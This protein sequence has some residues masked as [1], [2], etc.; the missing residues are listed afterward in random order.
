MMNCFPVLYQD[1]LFY[2]I[3]ARYKRMCGIFSKKALYRDFCNTEE[4]Q[5]FMYLPLHIKALVGNLPY[6]TKITESYIINNHT[7]YP[8]LT[9]F[10]SNDRADIIYSEMLAGSKKNLLTYVGANSTNSRFDKHLKYCNQCYKEDLNKLGESY[11]R[12]IHQI[13]GVLFCKK[14]KSRLIESDVPTN[15]NVND[16]FCADDVIGNSI[17]TSNKDKSLFEF[18]EL[19]IKYIEGVECLLNSKVQRKDNSFIIDYYLSKLREKKLASRSGSIY[20]KEF[21]KEFKEFYPASYL[22]SMKS[23]YDCDNANN[24]LRLFIRKDKKSKS[25]LRHILLMQFLGVDI[26]DVFK[27]NDVEHKKIVAVINKP[28]LDIGERK[29]Q[30]LRIIKENPGATRRQLKDIGK[31]VYTYIYKYQKEWYHK[32]T[33]IYENIKP[34]GD[35]VDWRERDKKCLKIVR[36]VVVEL[37]SKP[38]KPIRITK[39][40]IRRECGITSYFKSEKLIK[41]H[42]YIDSVVEDIDTYRRRKIKWAIEEMNEKGIWVSVYKVHQYAG[43]GEVKDEV[44]RKMVEKIIGE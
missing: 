13:P 34:K 19:N 30:W 9:S 43:F 4:R 18:Y 2:S 20:M 26:K 36:R 25:V 16:Y 42:E 11:W 35:I 17:I 44:V 39:N 8:Y 27:T 28:R 37:L 23:Y 3:A 7:M 12:R 24:W 14:H 33:P 41:T 1:E 6:S 31:G 22:Y 5:I 15:N 32:V 29:E 40:K 10:L 21:L 38:E